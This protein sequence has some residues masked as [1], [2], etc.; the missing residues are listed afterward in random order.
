[1]YKYFALLLAPAVFVLAGCGPAVQPISGTVT[2]QGAPVR[3]AELTLEPTGG[4]AAE[5]GQSFYG[6]APD[7]AYQIDYRDYGGLPQGEYKLKI[8]H[9]VQKNGEPV[10]DGEAGMALRSSGAVKTQTY[11]FDLKI[12]SG[13]AKHDF[14]LTEDHLAR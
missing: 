7:G 4:S 10:P 11:E 6:V 14:A 8:S 2:Y 5:V 13:A 9:R 12:V 1:L 3:A